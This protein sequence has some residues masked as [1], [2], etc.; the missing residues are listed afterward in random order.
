M[1]PLAEASIIEMH[2]LAAWLR[3]A[4]VLL[5]AHVGDCRAYRIRKSEIQQLTTDHTRITDN[6]LQRR[7]IVVFVAAIGRFEFDGVL[8]E[9]TRSGGVTFRLR[10]GLRL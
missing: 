2:T 1:E 8:A 3:W 10:R 7:D 9:P 6:G 4:L 5:L